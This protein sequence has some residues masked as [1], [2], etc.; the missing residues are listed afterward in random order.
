MIGIVPRRGSP[1]LGA[2]RGRTGPPIVVTMGC[3]VALFLLVALVF[4]GFGFV[5][6]LLWILAIIFFVCWMAGFAF[7]RGQRRAGR[8]R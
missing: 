4:V 6:H 1:G 3:L 2:V 8:R 5:I 7:S